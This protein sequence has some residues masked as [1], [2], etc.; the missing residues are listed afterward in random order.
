MDEFKVG[1]RVRVINKYHGQYGKTGIIQKILKYENC[2]LKMYNGLSYSFQD[3]ELEK[4]ETGESEMDEFKVG[5]RV[6]VINEYHSQ[7]NKTGVVQKTGNNK[8]YILKMD[9][10]GLVY[11]LLN[12][13]LEKVEEE[14]KPM[15]KFYMVKNTQEG[16][17]YATS[18]MHTTRESA[19]K[20]AERL[21]QLNPGESFAVLESISVYRMPTA[22]ERLLRELREADYSD[23][24]KLLDKYEIK[25]K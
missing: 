2:I 12:W 5:D 14:N 9:H 1:D 13:S 23:F 18:K 24:E 8:D 11:N 19:E 21:A 22:K 17:Q 15:I 25:E 20:E 16:K 10:S 6:R 7:Y 3:W 4:V